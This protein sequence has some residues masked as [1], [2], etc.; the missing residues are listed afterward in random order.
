MPKPNE[1]YRLGAISSH[2][3]TWISRAGMQAACQGHGGP[4][5]P[6]LWTTPPFFGGRTLRNATHDHDPV[7]RPLAPFGFPFRGFSAWLL[8]GS[9]RRNFRI[10]DTAVFSLYSLF[11]SPSR[12]CV[13][14]M[15]TLRVCVQ[16]T[17][18]PP[19]ACF[20]RCTYIDRSTGSW[21]VRNADELCRDG[22]RR[23]RFAVSRECH[24]GVRRQLEPRA[25][26][27]CDGD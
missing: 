6:I 17:D 18:A 11:F 12:I 1:T 22:Q 19:L 27:A 5:E 23:V 15:S 4:R 10:P 21:S 26:S 2:L 20:R 14:R 7:P 16:R 8:L 24:S 13:A 25:S 3:S 9:G